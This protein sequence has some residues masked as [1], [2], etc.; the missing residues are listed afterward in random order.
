MTTR[1]NL[2]EF[3]KH[4]L[5]LNILCTMK[6]FYLVLLILTLSAANSSKLYAQEK[7]KV[8]CSIIG[9]EHELK[10]GVVNITIDYGQDDL[11]KNYLVDDQGNKLQ[12]RTMISVMNYMSK[13]GWSLEDTSHSTNSQELSS[14]I[15]LT[16]QEM[17]SVRLNTKYFPTPSMTL[18]IQKNVQ[19]LQEDRW[20]VQ[21]QPLP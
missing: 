2:L 13:L 19:K 12:F 14:L 18:R 5:S 1:M 4:L 10:N 8:Y 20:M 16:H 3:I 11:K 21:H 15:I 7:H 6:R 9:N 17:F